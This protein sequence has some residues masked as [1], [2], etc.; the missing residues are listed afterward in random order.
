MQIGSPS[1]S[2]ASSSPSPS[3]SC[4]ATLINSAMHFSVQ[5]TL[6]ILF[7]DG[8]LQAREHEAAMEDTQW[9]KSTFGSRWTDRDAQCLQ[10]IIRAELNDFFNCPAFDHLREHGSRRLANRTTAPTKTNL[11][12]MVLRDLQVH[13]DLIATQRIRVLS[14]HIGMFQFPVIARI[15]IMLQD[16]FAIIHCHKKKASRRDWIYRVRFPAH[17]TWGALAQGGR[18]READVINPVPTS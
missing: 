11:C 1:T 13:T 18:N 5:Q 16:V 9:Q 6:V 14:M 8:L 10:N 2:T 4:A 7:G 17:P 15:A 3:S 12:H